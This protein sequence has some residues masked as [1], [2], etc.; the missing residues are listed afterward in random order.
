MKKMKALILTTLILSALL[1]ACGTSKENSNNE[2]YYKDFE[3]YDKN[4]HTDSYEQIGINESN[5]VPQ[6]IVS[7]ELKNWVEPE[8]NG[9][10]ALTY[11]EVM[12][13][14]LGATNIHSEENHVDVMVMS[15]NLAKDTVEVLGDYGNRYA[16]SA[17]YEKANEVKAEYIDI[18]EIDDM[19]D[20][21]YVLFIDFGTAEHSLYISETEAFVD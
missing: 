9:V 2:V 10:I 12:K 4:T 16:Y 19:G 15:D 11:Y 7:D 6:I 8:D 18:I 21:T 13:D 1:T 14:M 5:T 3:V 20:G 17:L